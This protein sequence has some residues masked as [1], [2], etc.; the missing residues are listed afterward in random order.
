MSRRVVVGAV[1]WVLGTAGAF[2]LDPIL[3]TAVLV[4]GGIGVV[5]GFFASTW[6]A[7]T[8]FEERELARA[9]RRAAARE[10]NK[11]KRAKDRARYQAAQARKAQREARRGAPKS[12]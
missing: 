7:G 8:T 3:G 1:V 10:Q 6:D 11:D 12:G 2:L 9:R 4:F 5:I